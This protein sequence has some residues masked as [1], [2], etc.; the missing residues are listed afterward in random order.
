MTNDSS[1]LLPS[2]SLLFPFVLRFVQPNAQHCV[3]RILPI[4]ICISNTATVERTY[5]I[6]A[7]KPANLELVDFKRIQLRQELLQ[8]F[9]AFDSDHVCEW[10]IK[11]VSHIFCR[12]LDLKIL[13]WSLYFV[14]HIFLNAFDSNVSKQNKTRQVLCNQGKDK[15]KAKKKLLL[16]EEKTLGHADSTLLLIIYQSAIIFLNLS[17]KSLLKS[18]CTQ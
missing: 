9:T 6:M 10:G 16:P 12:L 15:I 11:K 1:S 14:D 2:L 5:E 13:F 7:P 8:I 4:L 3:P 18:I 17:F